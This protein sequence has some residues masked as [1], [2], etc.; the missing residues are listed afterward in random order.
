[1][2]LL[3]VAY[4][5]LMLALPF[6]DLSPVKPAIRAVH[7]IRPGMTESEV[8]AVLAQQFPEHGR[9]KRPDFGVLHQDVLS[10]VLDPTDGR[11]NAA[12]VIIRFSGGK[13]V[14]AEFLPD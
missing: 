12:V 9:F 4:L 13:C 14:T 3:P 6:L 10:V 8:R 11:Y 1:M 2:L 5:L 7:T